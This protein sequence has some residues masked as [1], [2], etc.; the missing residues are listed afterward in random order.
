METDPIFWRKIAVFV[1][2]GSFLWSGFNTIYTWRSNSKNRAR[3]IKLEEFRGQ[4][5]DPITL[6]LARLNEHSNTT[7]AISNTEGDPDDIRSS[8]QEL[9]K[10]IVSDLGILRDALR[11]ANAS[12]FADNTDWLDGFDEAEGGILGEFNKVANPVNPLGDL[13]EALVQ[14]GT[15]LKTMR[16]SVRDRIEEE[17][18]KVK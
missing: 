18:A 12:K 9:N 4:I 3:G 7:T 8:A 1:A 16:G 10:K 17:I 5:R 14:A 15:Q 13:K 11:D 2:I 6:V